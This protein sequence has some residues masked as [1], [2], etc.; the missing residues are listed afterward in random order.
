MIFGCSEPFV[1][2]S[3]TQAVLEAIWIPWATNIGM[4]SMWNFCLLTNPCNPKAIKTLSE[5]YFLT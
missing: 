5:K 2:Y 3:G 1:S 4:D